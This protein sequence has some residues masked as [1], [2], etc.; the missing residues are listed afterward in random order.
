ME[1]ELTEEAEQFCKVFRYSLK[2][3]RLEKKNEVNKC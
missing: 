3:D 2:M 1:D